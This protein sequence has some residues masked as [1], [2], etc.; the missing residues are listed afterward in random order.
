MS[1]TVIQVVQGE[2]IEVTDNRPVISI[3][4][5]QATI[6]NVTGPEAI[7][8]SNEDRGFS[9]YIN[10]PTLDLNPNNPLANPTAPTAP[11]GVN[12]TSGTYSYVIVS[13]TASG[14]SL[15]KHAEIWRGT[16]DD[17]SLAS[18]RGVST[19]VTYQDFVGT[20]GTYYYWVRFVSFQNTPG[21][22]H[23][24]AGASSAVLSLLSA[25]QLAL[26]EGSLSS[27]M[28]TKINKIEP[29]EAAIAAETAA[30][31]LAVSGEAT[32]RA[33]ADTVLSD[34]ITAETTARGVAVG[35]NA[36]LI[37]NEAIARTDADDLLSVRITNL[38]DNAA[39]AFNW[40]QDPEF[41][42]R[43]GGDL[44]YWPTHAQ[45]AYGIL[46][47]AADTLRILPT[48]PGADYV[49]S[50]PDTPTKKKGGWV[51]FESKVWVDAG[52]NGSIAIKVR[53]YKQEVNFT[54]TLLTTTTHTIEPDQ[55]TD[56]DQWVYIYGALEVTDAATTH[57]R[58]GFGLLADAT[59]TTAGVVFDKV[60]F[61]SAPT[62]GLV[63]RVQAHTAD[64]ANPHVVTKAQ[65]GLGSAD[66]TSDADKPVS[67]A[68]QAAIAEVSFINALIIG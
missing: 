35:D 16:A 34:A 31:I 28:V 60:Y 9:A 15:V 50:L 45:Y 51:F 3:A 65:V 18:L 54:Y 59:S 12:L 33:D 42:A 63:N 52:F 14:Q 56:R 8:L 10:N 1:D 25:M 32:A 43:V 48:D 20:A 6:V 66:N 37:N 22:W 29:N 23:S 24:V 26:D 17:V 4:S 68:Q 36:T 27:A 58:H 49:I 67:T 46:H 2:I 47:G 11:L 57:V 44:T 7:V 30:R 62:E 5:T 61:G 41:T 19:G 13:W 38:S 53:E 40:V 21:A 64:T 39:A 55:F